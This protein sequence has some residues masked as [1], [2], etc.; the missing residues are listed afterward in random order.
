VLRLRPVLS[1][2][3]VSLK[4]RSAVL[5][6]WCSCLLALHPECFILNENTRLGIKT[7]QTELKNMK[8]NSDTKK[9]MGKML[10]AKKLGKDTKN[11]IKEYLE[12]M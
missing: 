10:I 3:S 9:F 1:L 8:I 7:A 6:H 4:I 12:K 5:I 2:T 11:V